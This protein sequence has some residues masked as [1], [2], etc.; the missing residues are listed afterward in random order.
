MLK[1]IFMSTCFICSYKKHLQQHLYKCK[2]RVTCLWRWPGLV[3]AR[4]SR[5]TYS[6]PGPVNTIR[7]DRRD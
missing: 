5:S 2:G 1:N 6:T 4:W 3:V 7:Y